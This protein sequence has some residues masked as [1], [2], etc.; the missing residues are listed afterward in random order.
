[1]FITCFIKILGGDSSYFLLTTP[2]T[3]NNGKENTCRHW[4]PFYS[5]ALVGPCHLL[6]WILSAPALRE[7]TMVLWFGWVQLFFWLQGSQCRNHNAINPAVIFS[8]LSFYKFLCG[9]V[10]G[11]RCAGFLSLSGLLFKTN[12]CSQKVLLLCNAVGFIIFQGLNTAI[13]H[14]CGFPTSF[15]VLT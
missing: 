1:M 11:E 15:S 6:G 8:L 14:S 2:L 13:F 9:G 4:R 10:L 3:S 12:V 5:R 7:S